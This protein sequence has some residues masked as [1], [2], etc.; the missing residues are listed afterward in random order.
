MLGVIIMRN[1]ERHT[2]LVILLLQSFFLSAQKFDKKYFIQTYWYVNNNYEEFYKSDTIKFIK[3]ATFAPEWSGKETD[4]EENE[5][6]N[7]GR[8]AL[9]ELRFKKANRLY[10]SWRN[11]RAMYENPIKPWS[12]KYK[13]KDSTIILY[14]EEKKVFLKFKPLF[15][16]QIEVYSESD[17]KMINTIEL[18]VVRT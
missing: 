14:D 1:P 6:R 18:T 16:R 3:H 2:F 8:G 13:K 15:E 12:W 9:V 11:R 7:S 4:Y 5:K 10:I 17:K